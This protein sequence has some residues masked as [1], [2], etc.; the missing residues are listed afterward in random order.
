MGLQS[1]SLKI[2]LV[3]KDPEVADQLV[4]GL[5]RKG[6]QVVIAR[7]QRQSTSRTRSGKPDILVVDVPSFGASGYRICESIRARLEGVPTIL[8]LDHGHSSA[9]ST[10]D[11]FMIPPFTSRK[12][13]Y[14]VKK[15]AET[16]SSRELRAG[17]LSLDPD[18]R[19][20][21]K[22]E[23][24]SY[25]RPKEAEL[26]ALFMRNPGKVLTRRQLMRDVWDTEYMGDTRTLSVHVRWVRVKIEE[27]PSKPRFLTTVR[28][29][30]YRF[31]VPESG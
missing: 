3:E 25:L 23:V 18:T 15:L 17:P 19:I 16:L 8:L 14:R 31:A 21:R 24:V 5:E 26:L 7:T 22:G 29:V 30:G 2:L 4:P 1:V 9:G 20:L 27:N 10:A 11:A 6:Y 12:L 13:I 28:G